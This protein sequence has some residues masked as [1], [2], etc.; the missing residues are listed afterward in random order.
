V[1]S[2]HLTDFGSAFKYFSA[3]RPILIEQI[4]KPI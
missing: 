2:V 1:F 3:W 4:Y